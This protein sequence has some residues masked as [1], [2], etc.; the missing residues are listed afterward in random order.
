MVFPRF[1]GGPLSARPS[2][3]S[4]APAALTLVVSFLASKPL[5]PFNIQAK[6]HHVAFELLT[7]ILQKYAFVSY[8]RGSWKN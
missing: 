1:L 8:H 6:V 2:G 7:R 5:T 4:W 3:A